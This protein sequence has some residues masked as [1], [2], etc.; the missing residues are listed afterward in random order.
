MTDHGATEREKVSREY[1][2]LEQCPK[3]FQYY[4]LHLKQLSYATTP[5][6]FAAFSVSLGQLH[7]L[8]DY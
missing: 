7:S 8:V 1:E 3:E 6:L 5:G 2:L 4:T